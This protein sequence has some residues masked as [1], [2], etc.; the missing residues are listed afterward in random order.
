MSIWVDYYLLDEP[1]YNDALLRL[2][3]VV[4]RVIFNVLLEDLCNK[5]PERWRTLTN[6]AGLLGIPAPFNVLACLRVLT[7]GR[8][9]DDLDDSARMVEKTLF[10]YLKHFVK[11]IITIYG[12]KFYTRRPTIS[13]RV[14]IE[15]EYA[16]IGFPGYV[17]AIAYFQL[18]LK[19]CPFSWKGHFHQSKNGCLA[20][21]Q[22]DA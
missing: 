9:M 18:P 1:T 6:A 10:V 14:D 19:S 7:K 8:S 17:V 15:C 16:A 20:T 2:R 22:V 12:T 3:F 13:E 11:D 5:F 4:P 21:I